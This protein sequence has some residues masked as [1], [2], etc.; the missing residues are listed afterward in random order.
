[1]YITFKGYKCLLKDYDNIKYTNGG[2]PKII[3]KTSWYKR[4]NIPV[5]LN[6][7]LKNIIFIN[8]EYKLYYFDDDEI[9]E[10]MK[11][12][13]IRAYKAYKKIIPSAFKID[14]FRYCFLE[15]YGGCYSDIGH[16]PYTSFDNICE[17]NK[18]I[19]VKDLYY[20]GIH[21]ALLCSTKKNSYIIKLV[22]EC[23]KNIELEYY[24][25][26]TLCITG[27]IFAGTIFYKYLL[28][29]NNYKNENLEINKKMFS[30]YIIPGIINNIKI[31]E[32]KEIG[33]IENTHNDNKY[34]VDINDNKYI[35]CKFKDYYK[36]LYPNYNKHYSN[37]WDMKNVYELY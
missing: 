29:Y 37:L 13:S 18:L 5:I 32:L 12:Y 10:F 19:I 31:L 1:M 36:I 23:I 2:I 3:I 17:N 27:P 33:D 6:N 34:I 8:P 22:E 11:S 25:Y 30:N 20:S 16:I 26:N 14:L 21:N 35:R 9:E 15:K 4:N 28:N 7:I 24:G